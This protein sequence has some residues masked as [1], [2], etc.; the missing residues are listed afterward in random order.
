MKGGNGYENCRLA[1]PC[2]F[3]AVAQEVVEGEKEIV[4]FFNYFF[5][6]SA[7]SPPRLRRA[8]RARGQQE[9]SF[10]ATRQRTN[11]ES[12]PRRSLLE[13]PSRAALQ[14]GRRR[15]TYILLAHLSPYSPTRA[16]DEESKRFCGVLRGIRPLSP[17]SWFVL[18]RTRKNEQ[19]NCSRA[20]AK[21]SVS[22]RLA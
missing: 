11:Q 8:A 22:V 10:F 4:G 18:S 9:C 21:H 3:G 1:F 16:A 7:H 12:A 19:K 6:A 20:R 5:L 13:L 15:K 14:S 17:L 2:V